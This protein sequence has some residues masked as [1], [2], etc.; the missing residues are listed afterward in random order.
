MFNFSGLVFRIWGVCGIVL[1]IGLIGI[2]SK[3]PWKQ[4]LDAKQIMIDLLFI[5][6]AVLLGA[7]YLS[8]ILFPGVSSYTGTYI[9][10]H[11]NS[12][13]APPLPVTYEYVFWNGEGNRQKFYLDTF[14]KKSILHDDLDAGRTYT[15]YF[16]EFTNIIVGI[17]NSE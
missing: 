3:R 1:F 16:D 4:V 14:S 5:G 7:V 8:R 11:R 2:L 12:R 13:V 10:T 9:E 6:I 15:I 17:E